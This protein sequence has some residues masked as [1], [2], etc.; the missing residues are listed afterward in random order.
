MK[1]EECHCIAACKTCLLF[2]HSYI[3]LMVNKNVRA[4]IL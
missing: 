2:T 1:H 4:C 3:L